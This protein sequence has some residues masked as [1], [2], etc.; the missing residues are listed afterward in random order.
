MEGRT[1]NVDGRATQ[2]DAIQGSPQESFPGLENFVTADAFHLS[3]N[4]PATFTQPG[5]DSFWTPVERE[6]ER[7]GGECG[8]ER[9]VKF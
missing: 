8:G 4:L 9:A 5:N 6:S 7:E 3:L 2:S 1:T